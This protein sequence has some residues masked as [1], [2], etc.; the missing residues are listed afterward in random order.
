MLTCYHS[1]VFCKPTKRTPYT[2]KWFD[3]NFCP[4]FRLQGFIGRMTRIKDRYWIETD[5]FI[6]SSNTTEN[7][8]IEGIQG[9]KYPNVKKP[10]STADNPSLSRFEI[11]PIAQIFCG[12]PEPVY[13]TQYD[14]IFVTYLDGFNMN[15]GQ[16]RPHSIVDQN[17]SGRI[18]FDT[19]NQKYILP[20]LIVSKHFAT[21]DYAAHINTK[22]DFTIN[23]VIKFMTVQELNTLHTVCEIER[24]QLLIILA[25]SVKNPQLAGFLLTGKRCNFLYVEGSTAWLY[26][27]PHFESPLYKADKC[28][29]RIPIH[30]RETIM[31]VDPITRQT[32]NYATPIECGN[33]PQK[34]IE[35]DP[36]T[37]DGDF[38]VL[39]PNPLK[40]E[41]PQMF[42]PTQIKTTIT[43]NTFTAQDAGIYSNADLDQFGNRVLFAKHSDTTLQLHGKSLSYDFI[44]V[45]N[46]QH[47]DT[48]SN[49]YN[50]LRIGLHDHLLNLLPLFNP[51]WFSQAFIN[52][53]GYPC[54]VL[55][56]CGIYYSTFLFIKEVLTFLFK[57]YRT[58]SIQYILQN[59]IS[60]LSSIAH[61]C[62]NIV[63]SEMVT[64]LNNTGKRKRIHTKHKITTSEND[65]ILL[66]DKET[67]KKTRRYSDSDTPYLPL[68][69][70]SKNS[71]LQSPKRTHPSNIND[72][73]SPQISQDY[74]PIVQN[75][76]AL[77]E[78]LAK[79]F[80]KFNSSQIEK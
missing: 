32:F 53:F 46:E 61:G 70:T 44:T 34:I 35:L 9:T 30:Y 54:Y 77:L 7:L 75:V 21:L 56:Q 24:T 58:I 28:F 63:T 22:I 5:K 74:D 67:Q 45:H 68:K 47:S 36:D 64:D 62:F 19:S 29:D 17:I 71:T 72:T 73:S 79:V 26:D 60:I 10:H 41:A 57:F 43:P 14:D 51:D 38:Y 33:N 8:Q 76:I 4:I 20:A 6:K 31:Y 65:N 3:E 55:T 42:K 12:K 13:S 69:Y 48:G 11:Y 40:K 16:L 50:H 78:S 39:T 80:I 66:S 37:A 2:L 49:P 18:Q 59:N 25:M 27:C 23:H 52:F 1:D 15:N